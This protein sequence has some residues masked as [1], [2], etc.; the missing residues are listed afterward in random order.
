MDQLARVDKSQVDDIFSNA[1]YSNKIKS[2]VMVVVILTIVIYSGC[3]SLIWWGLTAPHGC[4]MDV[5][6]SCLF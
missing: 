6:L 2:K 1:A 5:T 3:T 4:K